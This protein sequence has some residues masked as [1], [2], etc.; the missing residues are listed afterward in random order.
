MK[1][2][3]TQFGKTKQLDV[4]VY[5][6]SQKIDSVDW[7]YEYWVERGED[8]YGLMSSDLKDKKVRIITREEWLRAK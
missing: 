7:D 4:V 8:W 3:Y 2:P 1:A 6:N 5:K